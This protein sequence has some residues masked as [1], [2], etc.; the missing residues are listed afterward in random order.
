MGVIALAMLGTY[1]YS[2]IFL[3]L[4]ISECFPSPIEGWLAF[5]W[6]LTQVINA[7]QA[8]C[9]GAFFLKQRG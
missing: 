8:I 9:Y 4:G 5:V 2:M 6:L 7:I 3:H 1:W